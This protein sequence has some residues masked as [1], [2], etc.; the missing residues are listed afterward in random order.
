MGASHCVL[1]GL[2]TSIFRPEVRKEFGWHGGYPVG[3][4]SSLDR[5]G[6][7]EW[8]RRHLSKRRWAIPQR[9]SSS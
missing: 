6:A 3:S 7:D 9:C 5:G 2:L 1:P 8:F 4:D